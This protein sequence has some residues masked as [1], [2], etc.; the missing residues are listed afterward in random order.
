MIAY[1]RYFID[2]ILLFQCN[3]YIQIIDFHLILDFF[4]TF[5]ILLYLKFI[6]LLDAALKQFVVTIKFIINFI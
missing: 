4:L 5:Q 2:L 6:A 3:L 1:F